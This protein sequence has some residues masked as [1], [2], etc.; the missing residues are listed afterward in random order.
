MVV[1]HIHRGNDRNI[2]STQL[3]LAASV[4][5]F[6][7]RL[8]LPLSP[9]GAGPGLVACTVH[10][11]HLL[12]LLPPCHVPRRLARVGHRNVQELFEAALL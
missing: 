3:T 12:K 9:L 8:P 5:A 10:L 4:A 7:R 1:G 6:S 11:L 2:P